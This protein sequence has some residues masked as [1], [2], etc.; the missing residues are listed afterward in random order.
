MGKLN[1]I[2]LGLISVTSAL[3]QSAA[4]FDTKIIT[5]AA[6]APKVVKIAKPAAE[7]ETVVS[8]NVPSRYVG[9][10]ELE[11]YLGSLSSVFAARGREKDPFGHF[12]DPDSTPVVKNT[13]AKV[14][15]SAPAKA[16]PLS[17]IIQLITI[18]T[19]MPRDNSFLVGTR[20]VKQGEEIALIWR[21]KHIRVQVTDVTSRMIAFRNAE[22][23]ETGTR[24][25][26]ML[27]PGMRAG[28][29]SEG[30]QA[31]G[32][33]PDRPNAPIE[34]ETGDSAP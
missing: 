10:A 15:R 32:M 26:D 12:Q 7:K 25:L 1:Y 3:A 21:G 31:P 13:V 8:T 6:P 20:L 33:V 24:Q 18:T 9:S 16:T 30:I 19:I 22:T 2:C 27:P 29:G 4:N 11:A 5:P 14:S 23:G 28:N 17:E 34:L